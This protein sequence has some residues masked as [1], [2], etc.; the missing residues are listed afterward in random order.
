[1]RI[2]A[3]IGLV[4]I[5]IIFGTGLAML[6]LS[7]TDTVDLPLAAAIV[8]LVWGAFG[9]Y[10]G[11][12]TSIWIIVGVTPKRII[13]FMVKASRVLC[14]FSLNPFVIAAGMR[15]T[16]VANT[17]IAECKTPIIDTKAMREKMYQMM[18]SKETK[19]D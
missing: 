3:I 7:V 9:M 4:T 11:L 16:K 18:A 17:L 19:I 8:I 5:P 10:L 6:L 13:K 1:M 15:V 14:Y 12:F 2:L